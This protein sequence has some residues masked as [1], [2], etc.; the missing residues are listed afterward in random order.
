MFLYMV[1]FIFFMNFFLLF[2]SKWS[3]SI[4]L[5]SFFKKNTVDCYNVSLYC[6]CFATVF[7]RMCF[8]NYLCQIYFFNIELIENSAL[9]FPTCFFLFF[10][11]KLSSSS[12][13]FFFF[14]FLCFFF[15]IVFVIFFNM[16]LVENSA[17]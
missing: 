8:L 17:L 12:S 4:L 10:L 15:K 16:K 6:F 2:F 3:L 5:R 1:F 14:I 11:P 9:T 7:S 13:L